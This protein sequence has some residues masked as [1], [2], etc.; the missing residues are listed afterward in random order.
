MRDAYNFRDATVDPRSQRSQYVN[1]ALA[2]STGV[3]LETRTWRGSPLWSSEIGLS[4]P[5]ILDLN[6]TAVKVLHGIRNKTPSTS[7]VISGA[8]GP[9][10]DAYQDST[11]TVSF[12][13]AR[14]YYGPQ[15]HAFAEEGV[16][17]LCIMTVTNLDEATA[18][19]SLARE[20]TLPIH[21][22]FNVETD[23][24]LRGGRTLE[25]AI[26]EVDRLT[27]SY[28][29][30]FGVNCAHPRYIIQAVRGMHTDVRSRI[31]S[32]RG[33]SSLKS[34]DELDNS[35]VLDRGD[36]SVWFREFNELLNMLPDLKVVG[37]CCGTDEE[38][39]DAIASRIVSVS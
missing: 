11:G 30:Y 6:R 34:H 3:V 39:I 21:V 33:N 8:L 12:A 17:M 16:G 20:Y 25:H 26:R 5:Q 31:G 1:I 27:E 24:R 38:H 23:G 36:L 9:L 4:I 13:Q 37:G 22:S 15:I 10:Q 7:I 28:T 29:T 2:H 14:D 35:L 18:A 32:I 19:V